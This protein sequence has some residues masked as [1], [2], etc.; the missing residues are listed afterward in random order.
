MAVTSLCRFAFPLTND[1]NPQE[2]FSLLDGT[3]K[4]RPPT[5][6]IVHALRE[7]ITPSG[8]TYVINQD[9]S[10]AQLSVQIPISAS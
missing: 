8:A 9:S 7:S 4:Q 1:L 6:L 10:S 2:E 5:P 3:C